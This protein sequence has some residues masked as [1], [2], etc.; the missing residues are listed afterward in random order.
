MAAHPVLSCHVVDP[1]IKGISIHF[2]DIDVRNY[3]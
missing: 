2:M 3:Q 1:I